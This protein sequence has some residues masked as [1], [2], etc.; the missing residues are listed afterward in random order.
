MG[1]WQVSRNLG[2]GFLGGIL[3]IAVC[4]L[5]SPAILAA[6]CLIGFIAGYWHDQLVSRLRQLY[7]KL[8]SI[9]RLRI[10]SPRQGWLSRG[11][12]RQ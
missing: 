2:G 4:S 7:D 1:K 11:I 5:I 8:R 6:G 3:G 10:T 12:N 9:K